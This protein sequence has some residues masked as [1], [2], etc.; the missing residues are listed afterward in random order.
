MAQE[1]KKILS[2]YY[3]ANVEVE[4]M[5]QRRRRIAKKAAET[6]ADSVRGSMAAYPYIERVV[7]I[8]GN[9]E[10][11]MERIEEQIQDMIG[12]GLQAR[13][14][15]EEIIQKSEDAREREILRSRFIDCLS[16]EG[17]GKANHINPDHARRIVR[18]FIK[19]QTAG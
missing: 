7:R 4:R 17:V 6:V 8:E 13:A 19:N 14:A 10:A 5:K 18:E 16:W 11:V 9:Q 3:W 15:A 12:R 2:G 1:I